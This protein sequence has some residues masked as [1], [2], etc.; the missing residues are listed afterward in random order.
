MRINRSIPWNP[1][2]ARQ[3]VRIQEKVL[4]SPSPQTDWGE[5][6]YTWSDYAVG[7]AQVIGQAG[8]REF[9]QVQQI[10]SD[11]RYRMVFPY[12]SGV[13]TKMRLQWDTDEIHYCDILAARDPYGTRR[14]LELILSEVT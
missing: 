9:Q 10:W 3:R 12:I 7:W 4:P 8:N 2:L 13:T 5:D 11:A 14:V 1:G 6:T